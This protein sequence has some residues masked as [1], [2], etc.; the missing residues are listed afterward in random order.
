M[1]KKITCSLR[2]FAVRL[3]TFFLSFLISTKHL[4][5][6][7]LLRIY[8]KFSDLISIFD[9]ISGI[10]I[11]NLQI[12]KVDEN[13]SSGCTQLNDI[14]HIYSMA[15]SC[16]DWNT[17]SKPHSGS[18]YRFYELSAIRYRWNLN[19]AMYPQFKFNRLLDCNCDKKIKNSSI[20][21][22]FRSNYRQSVNTL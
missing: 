3:C 5:T 22:E 11:L 4:D 10:H 14:K 21:M 2:E 12:W 1:F 6:F 17:C 18:L 7:K 13:W 20:I 8:M 15:R 16:S 9:L 19:D